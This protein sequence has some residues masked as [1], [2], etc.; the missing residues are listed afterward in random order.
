MDN[1]PCMDNKLSI[2]DNCPYGQLSIH[3][4]LSMMDNR[5]SMHGQLSM[6]L[7]GQLSMLWTI[8]HSPCPCTLV[9]VQVQVHTKV[10]EG[11]A[12]LPPDICCRKPFFLWFTWC[13]GEMVYWM[14]H[15][16]TASPAPT[17]TPLTPCLPSP[18][19]RIR[20]ARVGSGLQGW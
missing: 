18:S 4:Q 19:L 1:C 9:Q 13:N 14:D 5:L 10:C 8:V 7:Y 3:G 2:M 20:S 15:C 6:G 12:E 16:I 17:S 11:E